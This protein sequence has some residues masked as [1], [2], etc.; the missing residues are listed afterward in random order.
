MSGLDLRE[1]CKIW[2]AP[3]I[4][5]LLQAKGQEVGEGIGSYPSF[6]DEALHSFLEC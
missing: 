6:V 5:P 2:S 1:T 3:S 4:I